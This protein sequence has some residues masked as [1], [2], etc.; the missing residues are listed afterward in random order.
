MNSLKWNMGLEFQKQ[1]RIWLA[2]KPEIPHEWGDNYLIVFHPFKDSEK[3]R[4]SYSKNHI[5]IKTEVFTKTFK[6][7]IFKNLE[8]Q[9]SQIFVYWIRHSFSE[10][11]LKIRKPLLKKYQFAVC[12]GES[13]TGIVLTINNNR[14]TGWGEVY[15]VFDN[16][17]MAK[18][19]CE[20]IKTIDLELFVYDCNYKLIEVY[21]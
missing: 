14:Y 19:Y 3:T 18:S 17:E 9:I 5:L 2:E 10:N 20:T 6:R 11:D 8:L 7:S 13:Q 16:L 15:L 1:M 12:R 4:F 21:R